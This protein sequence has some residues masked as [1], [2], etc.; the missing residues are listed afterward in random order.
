MQIFTLTL[1]VWKTEIKESFTGSSRWI[2][3]VLLCLFLGVLGVHRFAAKRYR[4]GILYLITLG[5]FGLGILFDLVCLFLNRFKD[6]RGN[7]VSSN[8]TGFTKIIIF[9]SIITGV[10]I[11]YLVLEDYILQVNIIRLL[12][13][14]VGGS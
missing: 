7:T 13:K 12:E 4:S 14:I 10:E 6:S 8:F 11:L 2:V 9:L 5:I 1:K 3:F